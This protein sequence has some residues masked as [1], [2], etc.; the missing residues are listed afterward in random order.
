M[1]QARTL[2]TVAADESPL[3]HARLKRQLTIEEAAKRA[4]V[5]PEEVQWLEEGRLYRF[6]APDRAL[7]VTLLY[8]TALGVDHREALELAGRYAGS[9]HLQRS[10]H[11]S[12]QQRSPSCSRAAAARTRSRPSLLPPPRPCP[13]RGRSTSSS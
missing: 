5:T 4:G 3:A 1:E 6:P 8:A 7:V 10:Q 2:E 12:S 9:V 11:S 13:R